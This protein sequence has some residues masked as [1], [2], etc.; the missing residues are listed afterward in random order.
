ML[1][2]IQLFCQRYPL[3]PNLL[4]SILQL[5]RTFCLSPK[6]PCFLLLLGIS[7]FWYLP[8]TIPTYSPFLLILWDFAITS[9]RMSSWILQSWISGNGVSH[10]Q[11]VSSL[12]LQADDS[13]LLQG[14]IKEEAQSHSIPTIFFSLCRIEQTVQY[15]ELSA[16]RTMSN[17]GLWL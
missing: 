15:L 8:Q 2:M 16:S 17:R 6:R 5:C 1:F 12:V 14:V 4:P 13:L 9:S 11:S 10:R 7:T 3:A